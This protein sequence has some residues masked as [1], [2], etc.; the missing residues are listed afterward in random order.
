M[1]TP[2]PSTTVPGSETGSTGGA[3]DSSTGDE[4][5]VPPG[6]VYGES[7]C[8]PDGL[9]HVYVEAWFDALASDCVPARDTENVLQIALRDWDGFPGEF[10]VGEMNQVLAAYHLE[11]LEGAL[12]LEV[13]APGHPSLLHVSLFGESGTHFEGIIDLT[14]CHDPGPHCEPE[15]TTGD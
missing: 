3:G 14:Q 15:S 12:A 10:A 6:N 5:L 4:L 9:A 1:D 8:Q 13:W 2:R 7:W 11:S